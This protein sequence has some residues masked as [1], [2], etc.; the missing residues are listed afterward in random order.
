MSGERIFTDQE[1]KEMGMRTVDTVISAIDAGDYEKAKKMSRRM[2]KE[3]ESMHDLYRDWTTSLM[4]FIYKRY[5]DEALYESL[6]ESCG[7][8]ISPLLELYEQ[9]PDP[10]RRAKMLAAGLRGHLQPVEIEEDDEKFIFRMTPCGS[11]GRLIR[12][13]CYEPPK[14]FARVKNAQAMTY[15]IDDLPI[16]CAHCPFQEIIPVE[17]KG[18]P[19]FVTIPSGRLGEEPCDIYLY[20]DVNGVPEEY[21]SRVGKTK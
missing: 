13:G 4:S 15:G 3:F 5:G 9:T 19:L 11:G 12:E 18:Y 2:Y 16:Y 20:K 1:L 17:L 14:N 7:S 8:W 10:K 21:F 6:S